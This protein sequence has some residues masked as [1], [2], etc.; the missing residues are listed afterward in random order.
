MHGGAF[1]YGDLDMPEADNVSRQLAGSGISVVSVDYSLSPQR[2]WVE[3]APIAVPGVVFPVASQEVLAAYQW[4]VR[5][6]DRRITPTSWAL[7]GASAGANLAVGAALR[8]RDADQPV[9]NCLVLAYP[10]LHAELPPLSSEL[11]RKLATLPDSARLGAETVRLIS[12]NY[13]G[14]TESL[15]ECAYAFPGGRDLSGLPPTFILNSDYDALRASGE[16]FAMELKDAHVQV[17]SVFE[18]ASRHGHLNDPDDPG[19]DQ[20]LR[21]LSGW[22]LNFPR[23][24]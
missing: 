4:A 6:A 12:L 5:F 22:L 13:V 23:K 24:N 14:G 1:A 7:G 9:S 8:L 2:A 17:D 11:E 20:S 19:T 21:R 16:R 10:L 3:G 15:L 18:P